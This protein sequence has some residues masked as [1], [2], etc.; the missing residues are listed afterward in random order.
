[1]DY[2]LPKHII[3]AL[4]KNET[5]LGEHPS[6]P[7]DEED[8]F[9][10]YLLDDYYKEISSSIEIEDVELIKKELQQLLTRC[11]KIESSCLEAL[12]KLCENVLNKIFEIPEETINI[13]CKLTDNI[14]VSQQRLIP[15]RTSDFSFDDID[16]MSYLTQEIYKRRMLNA[17][18]VG[19]SMVY[20]NHIDYYVQDL[21][22]INPELPSLYKR[23]LDL[24][25]KLLY[26]EKDTLNMK[27]G[28][29]AGK[30]DVNIGS[31]DEK[32]SINAEAIIFPVLLEETIKG[33]LEVAIAH[34]LP[35]DIK[36]AEY[37][38][39]KA[40]FKLAEN[41]DMRIGVP[42]WLQ[43]MSIFEELNLDVLDNGMINFFLYE[44]AQMECD[45]FNSFLQNVFKGTKKGKN[46]IQNIISNIQHDKE[47]DD[48]NDFM[49]QKISSKYVL[50]DD[51]EYFT[52][53]ELLDDSDE[54][55]T[56]EELIADSL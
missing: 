25:T 38:I 18:I 35:K 32:I 11:K 52:S 23:I 17:L 26:K 51:E 46:D 39:K 20:S 54:Y 33:I 12:E 47:L 41:W 55:F 24:N 4:L 13:E 22:K 56:S 19:A 7:P 15:E 48:F 36:K 37:V 45:E 43:I 3:S 2:K 53:E 44:V 29:E 34:G 40:D 9:L 31:P 27:E 30:V 5:S 42:L 8:K 14:D 6:L 1:M 49:S 21:F 50:N 28:F 16:D 10:I